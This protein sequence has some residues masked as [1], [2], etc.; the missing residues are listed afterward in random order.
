MF[1][2]PY[3]AHTHNPGSRIAIPSPSYRTCRQNL[4]SRIDRCNM[5]RF[6]RIGVHENAHKNGAW[7]VT[8]STKSDD[9]TF[10]TGG[11]DGVVRLWSM[12][13]VTP[14]G[15]DKDVNAPPDTQIPSPVKE[16]K[17]LKHHTLGVVSVC[18]ASDST[19][20]GSVALDGAMKV[21]DVAKP[22]VEARLVSGA[23]GVVP[24]MWSLAISS[25]GTCAV[26][27][28]S[29]GS[30]H[31]IDTKMCIVDNSFNFDPEAAEGTAPM[32]L[33]VA[34]S[35]DMTRAVV[36]AHD[37]S[38]RMFDVETGKSVTPRMEGHSGPVR[39]VAFVPGESSAVVT[40]SDDGLV[41]YFDLDAAHIAV[42]LRGH[43]GM[44]L[45][46]APSPCGKYVASGG[47]D[48]NVMIWDK[49]MRE[50]VYGVKLHDDSVWGVAYVSDGLRVVS[51]AD[52]ESIGVI[53]C[54]NADQVKF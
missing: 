1:V 23:P 20:A 35:P 41:N 47:T 48:R 13:E 15:D 10:A 37:G 9:I 16:V 28:G 49:K 11:A 2:Q 36:G 17:E 46:A 44:V 39:S 31:V 30:L 52:D 22:G 34:L 4:S 45:S 18:V 51:V 27:G 5:E 6:R 38:V 8:G 3:G 25:D 42:S 29:A 24:D 40:C 53:D 32:C 54:H 26:V 14:S 33:S 43:P 7:C 12:N 19:V 50:S 21:W